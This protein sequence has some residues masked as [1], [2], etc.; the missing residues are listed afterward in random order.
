[1]KSFSNVV[2]ATV[3]GAT[4][5]LF[6]AANAATATTT[7]TTAATSTQNATIS[8]LVSSNPQL[9]TLASALKAAGMTK[10]LQGRGPFTLFAPNN[11]AFARVPSSTLTALMQNQPKLAGV[12]TYHVIEGS[13]MSS[14]IKNGPVKT[15]NGET[16]NV[17]VK[18]GTVYVNNA[19]AIM[20]NVQ[21][22][23][24]VI[25]VINSVLMPT[26]IAYT[27]TVKATTSA[28]AASKTTAPAAATT[29]AAAGKSSAPAATP[30]TKNS[31]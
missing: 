18:N 29:P 2:K 14:Q 20:A 4:V 3:A 28:P 5:L 26:P 15:A 21:A 19:K 9:S 8:Q 6:S 23:N 31:Y 24:G 13:L 22:K 11:A 30:T 27:S 1:M 12:L 17:S 7:A 16:V 25:Y 10:T